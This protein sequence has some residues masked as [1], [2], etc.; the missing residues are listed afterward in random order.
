MSSFSNLSP[1]AFNFTA[2]ALEFASWHYRCKNAKRESRVHTFATDSSFSA[3]SDTAGES[4]SD[5]FVA[6]DDSVYVDIAI[7]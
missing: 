5:I 2:S 4:L 1:S 7:R 6:E 3:T